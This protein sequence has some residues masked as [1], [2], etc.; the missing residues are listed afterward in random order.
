MGDAVDSGRD[1]VTLDGTP[2]VLPRAPRYVA[3]Y[4]PRGVLVSRVSQG[5]RPTLYDALPVALRGL[6]PVGRL[7][8]DSEGLLLLTDDGTLA[9]ALLHPRSAL[10]RRYEVRVR[11]VPDAAAMRTLRA[12]AEVEGVPVKPRRVTLQGSE[13]GEGVLLVELAEGRK[14]EIRV[15]ARAAGLRVERLV[16]VAFGPL[17][18]G[19]LRPGATRMLGTDEVEALRAAAKPA[20]PRGKRSS[21]A[22]SP[23]LGRG[24]TLRH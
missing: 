20:V 2:L 19:P 24:D 5:G 14:R 12:G 8:R 21:A 17:R 9:E 18:L 7:D 23:G 15:F 10:P 4:K 1:R 22:A 16:R 13:G 6:N 3:Y 11:P